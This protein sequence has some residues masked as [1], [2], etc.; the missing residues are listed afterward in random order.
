M[1]FDNLGCPNPV[2]RATRLARLDDLPDW[3][4]WL[5]APIGPIRWP[6]RLAR[7]A[8]GPDCPITSPRLAPIDCRVSSGFAEKLPKRL[9]ESCPKV[10]RKVPQKLTKSL[11]TSCKTSWPTRY[12][13]S[14]P[15]MLPDRGQHIWQDILQMFYKLFCPNDY[16]GGCF[17]WP[18]SEAT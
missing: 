10:C 16:F 15:H 1:G 18:R 2:D 9:S 7:L 12:T 6:T 11:Q 14:C 5:A 4:D 13:N 8:G 17:T 3:P